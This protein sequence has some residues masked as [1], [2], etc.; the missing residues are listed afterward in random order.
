MFVSSARRSTHSVPML[1]NSICCPNVS[2]LNVC[3]YG[4]YSLCIYSTTALKW[5]ERRCR[6][7]FFLN[8]NVK[9][10]R[11][12]KYQYRQTS[13]SATRQHSASG[14]LW[15]SSNANTMCVCTVHTHA[16]GYTIS[17]STIT[18][19]QT[20]FKRLYTYANTHLHAAHQYT[21]DNLEKFSTMRC[22]WRSF[23]VCYCEVFFFL[24]IL[25][26]TIH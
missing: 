25:F 23:R 7:I 17:N 12:N 5:N 8:K 13:Y 4:D 11:A 20:P 3:L 22:Q 19:C 2:R 16:H 26:Q 1:Y 9:A 10:I 21:A 15:A 14:T 6:F 18:H 24:I